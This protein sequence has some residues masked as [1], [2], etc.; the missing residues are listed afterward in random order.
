MKFRTKVNY[1]EIIEQLRLQLYEVSENPDRTYTKE[2]IPVLVYNLFASE[3]YSDLTLVHK[4]NVIREVLI[5]LKIIDVM[6]K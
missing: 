4:E 6:K 2:D 1:P 5:Q 3:K